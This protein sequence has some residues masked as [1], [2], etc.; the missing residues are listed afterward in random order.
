MQNALII[1]G[2]S[3]KCASSR[4]VGSTHLH[5]SDH[6]LESTNLESTKTGQGFRNL[7]SSL[8]CLK[9]S[10]LWLRH[11]TSLGSEVLGTSP[12]P[13]LWERPCVVLV[14]PSSEIDTEEERVLSEFPLVEGSSWQS[15]PRRG[16][17]I[18]MVQAASFSWITWDLSPPFSVILGTSLVFTW[19]LLSLL[20][21]DFFWNIWKQFQPPVP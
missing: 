18:C 5:M 6:V 9:G 20:A 3:Q 10:L 7:D 2:R 11:D 4:G 15:I 19:R 17:M 13:S 12:G 21:P 1:E 8:S 14:F 16:L